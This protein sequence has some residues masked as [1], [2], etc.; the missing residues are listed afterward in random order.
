MNVQ[1]F[2]SSLRTVDQTYTAL[3]RVPARCVS[4]I[5]LSHLALNFEFRQNSDVEINFATELGFSINLGRKRN[6][7]VGTVKI[8]LILQTAFFN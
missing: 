5:A 7:S 3:R 6:F 4:Q 1:Q 2:S 8:L